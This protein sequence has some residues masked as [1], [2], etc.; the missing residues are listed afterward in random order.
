MSYS[1]YIAYMEVRTNTYCYYYLTR[2]AS[3]CAWSASLPQRSRPER[4]WREALPPFFVRKLCRAVTGML[5]Y[6]HLRRPGR[7][8]GEEGVGTVRGR[9]KKITKASLIFN[10]CLTEVQQRISTPRPLKPRRREDGHHRSRSANGAAFANGKTRQSRCC[11]F[12]VQ[13]HF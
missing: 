9:K 7:W 3:M 2:G 8:I 10:L 11:P 4:V 1:A 5:R 12:H 13:I 6:L